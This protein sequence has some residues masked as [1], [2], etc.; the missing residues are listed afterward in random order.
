MTFRNL[1]GEY[2]TKTKYILGRT[3]H[4]VIW[5]L[6]NKYIVSALFGAMIVMAGIAFLQRYELRNPIEI[7][8]QA[9]YRKIPLEVN[10]GDIQP[11]LVPTEE[12]K[13]INKEE[14]SI[15][16]LICMKWGLKECKTAIVVQRAENGTRQ[17]DRIHK[18]R[19]G[20]IDVGLYQ[21]N[22]VHIG[23]D[24]CGELGDVVTVEGNIDCAYNIW[25]RADGTMGNGKGNW[26][27]WTAYTNGSYLAMMQ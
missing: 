5:F 27:P 22:L 13:N 1:S 21:I 4:A 11:I 8:L 18:N 25:D 2:T 6:G 9:P 20:T 24:Y 19:N 23:A 3:G 16:Q 12:E 10:R 7:K 14:A 15:D 26:T 17:L